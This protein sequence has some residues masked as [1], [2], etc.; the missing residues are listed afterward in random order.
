MKKP[1]HTGSRVSRSGLTQ[2]FRPRLQD[3][4]RV[5]RGHRADDGGRLAVVPHARRED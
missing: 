5:A 2:G 3:A 1:D 4:E